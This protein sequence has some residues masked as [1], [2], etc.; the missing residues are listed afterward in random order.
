MNEPHDNNFSADADAVAVEHAL[1]RLRWE[2]PAD[3][4]AAVLAAA[5]L[6]LNEAVAATPLAGV[7]EAK[8]SPANRRLFLGRWRTGWARAVAAGL[9][10]VGA[11][12][13][14][15]VLW[16][17]PAVTLAEVADAVARQRWIHVVYDNG[18][19]RWSSLADHT[20]WFKD[21]SGRAVYTEPGGK[22]LMYWPQ[23]NRVD[24]DQWFVGAKPPPE[25]QGHDAWEQL[26]VPA[27]RAAAVDG[28]RGV[29]GASIERHDDT[30]HGH[31]KVV[32]FDSYITDALGGRQMV[33]QLWA[34]PKTR[35]PVRV[36][37]RLQLGERSREHP[38]KEWITGEF[39]F[40]ETGP[41]SL[42]DLGVP[43]DTPVFKR[44][45]RPVASV[46]ELIV[47][48]RAAAGRFP[49][50]YRAIKRNATMPGGEVDVMWRDGERLRFN[51]YFVMGKEDPANHLDI[52][53]TAEQV[54]AWIPART[55]VNVSLYD[56]TNTYDKNGPFPP[57][58]P[59]VEPP[60]VQ[61][62]RAKLVN[63]TM[64]PHERQWQT[65]SRRYQP[66]AAAD[67]ADPA[68]VPASCVGIWEDVGAGQRRE[69]W[70]DPNRDHLCVRET[71]FRKFN[72]KWVAERVETL[73]EFAK[74]PGGQWYAYK[75]STG[76]IVIPKDPA[77]PLPSSYTTA[78]QID[79]TPLEPADIPP[80]LFDGK[81]LT[82]GVKVV[83]Y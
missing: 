25:P 42:A 46:Q 2:A 19:E 65:S 57:S 14:C 35:L 43:K 70:I 66:L 73:D 22:R 80:G 28:G 68:N 36:R 52:P 29:N 24:E 3:V 10:L 13:A 17:G 20:Q 58:I 59:S 79:V 4:D 75:A 49:T 61:V 62:L 82:K 74:L 55:P 21:E 67:S 5:G 56:G 63:T 69:Y 31:G 16:S 60:Y 12:A 76:G 30:L 45:L 64:F 8:P 26:V 83:T 71:W 33:T 54:L 37:Q 18:R 34:D 23:L 78:Y 41:T 27:E 48:S 81:E 9:V 51:H 72:D 7:M 38:D 40:P 39:S 1:R 47:A 50:R 53:A 77:E 11:L 44:D 15:V 6:A 32:R